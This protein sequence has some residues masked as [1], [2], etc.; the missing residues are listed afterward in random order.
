MMKPSGEDEHST[1]Y[2]LPEDMKWLGEIDGITVI[3][4]IKNSNGVSTFIS[5]VKL[6]YDTAERNAA[7]IEEACEKGDLKL[8]STKLHALKS[9][10]TIIG[11]VK[12]SESAGKLEEAA[13]NEELETVRSETEKI[14]AEYK[15]LKEKLA[16]IRK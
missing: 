3:E 4:G 6:F 7:V 5:S 13:K 14:L 1:S 9:S 2:E 12:L 16:A 15:G 8:Y 10:A 11:A